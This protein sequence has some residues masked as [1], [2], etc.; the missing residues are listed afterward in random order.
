MFD[1]IKTK[2]VIIDNLYSEESLLVTYGNIPYDLD[3]LFNLYIESLMHPKSRKM[4]RAGPVKFV[5]EWMTKKNYT[6][7][8]VFLMRHMET[9]KGEDVDGWNVD[10]E[11]ESEYSDDQQIQLDDLRKK[12]VTKILTSDMNLL[13]SSL[14]TKLRTYDKLPEEEKNNFN[15]KEH[16]SRIEDR[17]SFFY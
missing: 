5:M 3:V 7:C 6:D 4:I 11:P 1:L 13:K 12:Y 2:C 9:Y 8:G 15:T 10:I 17:I 14:H 16:L